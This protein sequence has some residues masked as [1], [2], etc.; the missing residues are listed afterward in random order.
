MVAIPGI[1]KIASY[2]HS[3]TKAVEYAAPFAGKVKRTAMELLPYFQ[4][5][6]NAYDFINFASSVNSGMNY[7]GM[8]V[9]LE[10]DIDF[11]SYT[12]YFP[13]IGL[14]ESNSFMGVFD[15]K[16]HTLSNLK[17]TTSSNYAGLF[18]FTQGT[19]I[20]NIKLDSTCSITSISTKDDIYAGGLVGYCAS[21]NTNECIIDGCV[22]A[23]K[24]SFSSN[25]KSSYI[26]TGG[27]IGKCQGAYW[28]GCTIIN[29]MSYGPVEHEG[30]VGKVVMEVSAAHVKEK[31]L[32]VSV[33]SI[34]V[35]RTTP[36]STVGL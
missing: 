6:N 2:V 30:L 16:G 33:T 23:A 9:Y 13:P 7:S 31:L 34:I 32:T 36:L 28:K 11:S 18:G 22:S 21:T 5:I 4:F 1:L 8:T 10:T 12:G 20:K 27:L 14:N 24:M 29:S 26:R 17:V 35:G 19:T 25:L 15:G 3:I